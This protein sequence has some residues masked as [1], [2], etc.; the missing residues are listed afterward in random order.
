[1]TPQLATLVIL[2]SSARGMAATDVAPSSLAQ[3]FEAHPNTGIVAVGPSCGVAWGDLDADG[4]P[5]LW[6]GNHFEDPQLFR[7]LGDGT[8]EDVTS[9]VWSPPASVDSHTAAWVDFDQDGDQDLFEIAGAQHGRGEG[10]NHLFENQNG[11][12]VDRARDWALDYPLGRSHSQLWYDAH[13]DGQLDVVVTTSTRPDGEAPSA[14][15]TRQGEAFSPE[16]TLAPGEV[17]TLA[18]L[19]DLTGDHQPEVLVGALTFPTHAWHG[20]EP[21]NIDA[22]PITRNA[23]DVVT[24]DFDGDLRLDLFVATN[25]SQPSAHQ[26]SAK[27]IEGD[28]TVLDGELGFQFR[29]KGSLEFQFWQAS[30]LRPEDIFL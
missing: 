7:N 27:V 6:L 5:D 20:P 3:A 13:G 2:G 21:V 24:A 10:A 25:R 18:Q 1:M 30:A 22:I 28:L 8:F 9:R 11:R 17:I 16:R 4:W 12:L 29:T 14:L 19:L 23:R 26:A 15:F